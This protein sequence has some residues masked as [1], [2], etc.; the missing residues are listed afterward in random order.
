MEIA[1][2]TH[3][4]KKHCCNIADQLWYPGYFH[5]LLQFISHPVV[6]NL[7][8]KR[9]IGLFYP[10]KSYFWKWTLLWLWCLMEMIFFPFMFAILFVRDKT[11]LWMKKYQGMKGGN[12]FWLQSWSFRKIKSF[13]AKR[14]SC[15]F[16]SNLVKE[17][18]AHKLASSTNG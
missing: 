15:N 17:N 2:R 3:H 16:F 18:D 6:Y 7:L 11:R 9:W 13:W 5:P 1:A 4:S 8:D 12:D 14:I 10:W